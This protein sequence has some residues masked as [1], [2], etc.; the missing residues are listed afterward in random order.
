MM[1]RRNLFSLFVLSLVLSCAFAAED[2]EKADESDKKEDEKTVSKRGV[3]HHYSDHGHVH[4]AIVSATHY[5][6]P[7]PVPALAK[8][9]VLHHHKPLLPVPVVP[10]FV[11]AAPALP[12]HYHITPGGASVTSFSINYPRV[13]LLPRPAFV[14]PVLAAAPPAILP[15]HH[16]HHPTFH[17]HQ[18]SFHQHSAFVPHYHQHS[19]YAP[20]HHHSAYIPHHHHSAYLPHH[21]H[22]AY[23]PHHHHYTPYV[24]HQHYTPH[25]HPTFVAPKP[26]IPVAVPVPGIRQPKFPVFVNQKPFSSGFPTAYY[27]FASQAPSFV[28]VAVPAT[29]QPVNPTVA[30]NPGTAQDTNMVQV[31]HETPQIPMPTQPTFV[32]QP[33]EQM[34]TMTS[35]GFRPM[36]MTPNPQPTH[37]F[38]PM[39]ITPNPQPTQT[40]FTDKQPPY[41]YHAPAVPFNHDQS[42]SSNQLISGHG[43]M[44]SQLAHQL[45]LYQQ[46]QQQYAQPQ[47]QYVQQQ[48]HESRFKRSVPKKTELKP[49]HH[50]LD[51]FPY[52]AAAETFSQNYDSASNAGRYQGL[53]S[54]Q[55]PINH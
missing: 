19:A 9:P 32:H 52:P 22:S 1:I 12:P 20:H 6:I 33:T 30:V 37:G 21:H 17:H 54:Y 35:H 39:M 7:Q 18:P 2:S 53:S 28:P 13:P 38:R 8:F 36:M 29:P 34:P 47:Q 41:N 16:D 14:P 40:T 43:P 31:T 10:H 49:F 24:P 51:T 48:Q 15:H 45:A 5:H 44:S 4:P 46:Q 42:S 50:F 3:L 25:Y 26:I 55:V 27:P 11:P 23:V